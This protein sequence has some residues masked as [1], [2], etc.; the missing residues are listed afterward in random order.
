MDPSQI[1]QLPPPLPP[2]Q[3]IGLNQPGAD[4]HTLRG[5]TWNGWEFEVP[6][7]VFLPG[8]TSRMI[9][10]R[11]LDD[12]IDV[13][14]RV[15]AAMGAGLGVEAVVAGLR[16]AER[17]LAVDVHPASVAAAEH[18]YHRLV[19]PGGGSEF[20]PLV[21]DL[22]AGLPEGTRLDTVTFNPPAVSQPVS[23]DPDIVRN[24]CAGRP[25]TDAFFTQLAERDLLAPG[26]EV[27]FIASNTADL[28]QIIGHAADCGFTAHVHHLHDWDDGVLTYLFR[29]TRETSQ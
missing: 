12:D 23:D 25:V 9:H 21:S 8:A 26:G 6:P 28:R 19:G 3:I 14:E 20:V 2:E 1:A 11:I 15:Y 4:L 7:G 10:Q 17:V 18:N 27:Y 24:V 16:G 29:L 5:Y 13:R 22:F